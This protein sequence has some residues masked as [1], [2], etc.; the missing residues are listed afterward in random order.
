MLK[1]R[2]RWAMARPMR[3]K[4]TMPSVLPLAW[5]PSISRMPKLRRQPARM[6]PVCSH[7]RRQA[8]SSSM[9]A[10]SAVQSVSTSGVLVTIRP[11][12]LAAATSMWSKPTLHVAATR[13]VAGRR[14]IRSAVS[15]RLLLKNRASAWWAARRRMTSSGDRSRSS[16]VMASNS[17][18]ARAVTASGTGRATSRRGFGMW[19]LP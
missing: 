18:W 16:D 14:A 8:H 12:A 3:P 2:A 19:G 10:R 11:R 4:P 9:N 13:T 15:F 17:V 7:A 5:M 1:P 6:V